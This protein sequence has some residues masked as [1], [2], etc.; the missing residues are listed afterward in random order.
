MVWVALAGPGINLT[1]AV[2]S[3][4][5]IHIAVLIPGVTG[6]WVEQNLFN[7]LLI[8]L[9]LAVFNMLPLPPLDGGRVAV[10]LLPRRLGM[11]LARL[12]RF[13][14][15]IL[16]GIIFILPMIAGQLGIQFNLLAIVIGIP[17]E[18]LIQIIAT[19]TGLV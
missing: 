11:R 7:S 14:L 8:N 9:V 13:G 6:A 3:A 2:I 17:V 16:I 5:L 19:L 18:L 12:E 15:L 1:L 10:G 4:L